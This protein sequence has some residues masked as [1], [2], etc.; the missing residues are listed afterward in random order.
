MTAR[1]EAVASRNPLLG[2][3]IPTYKRPDQLRRCVESIIRTAAPHRVPIYVADDST[4]DTNVAT[5]AALREQYPLVL[6]HRNARNLGIDGNILHAVDLCECRH[7][8]IIGEDDRMAPEAVPTVLGVLERG[9][10][11]FVYV[12][13][14]SVDED[15]ALVLEERSLPLYA[16]AEKTAEEFLASDA[17]SMGFIGACV[18]DMDLWR[19]VRPERYVGT[20]YAHVGVIME[21]LCG[22]K[23]HL[24]ANPLV[25]NRVGTTRA[26]TW[27]DSTFEVLHG[28]DRMLALLRRI[29]P[30]DACDRS[31]ASYRRAHGLGSLRFFCY[32]RADG[33]LDA[34]VHDRYVRNGP[35]PAANRR[36]AW[37]IA[38]TPP[39]L[40]RAARWA[41]WEYRKRSCRRVSGH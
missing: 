22:R 10:H 39:G 6:H 17:W 1:P 41:L 15:V 16:D 33:A 2:I 32:L 29:Y 25:L 36:A 7:A 8:W 21:Y 18:V 38:R 23:V 11:P 35:Y 5:I 14:A 31:S 34:S 19:G 3:C 9:A 37:L 12:N 24:V 40:F 20:Y 28:W 27:T 30:A 4:D 26:F 13:Y